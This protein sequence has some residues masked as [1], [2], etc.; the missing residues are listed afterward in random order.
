[1]KNSLSNLNKTIFA[2]M[3]QVEKVDHEVLSEYRSSL[4][5]S[6]DEML[7]LE[8]FNSFNISIKDITYDEAF[9]QS[10]KLM[11][12]AIKYA[13]KV[14]FKNICKKSIIERFFNFPI[15]IESNSSKLYDTIYFLKYYYELILPQMMKK[16]D[17]NLSTFDLKVKNLFT[18]LENN[19]QETIILSQFMSLKNLKINYTLLNNCLSSIINNPYI[20]KFYIDFTEYKNRKLKQR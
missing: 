3:Q 17:T 7:S 19:S 15:D 2:N 16:I 9:L 18:K 14:D 6:K 13:S 4:S 5:I 1:M 11:N 10:L 20:A 8:N 12:D